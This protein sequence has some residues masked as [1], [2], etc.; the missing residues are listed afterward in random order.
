[1]QVK[2]VHFIVFV[3]LMSALGVGLSFL[4]AALPN[5][6]MILA[7]FLLMLSYAGWTVGST[8]MLVTLL[9]ANLRSGG[10]GPWT[11]FQILAYLII[12]VLWMLTTKLPP[13]RQQRL[14]QTILA[15]ILAFSFGFWNA[16]FNVPFYRI[17]NFGIYYLQGLPFDGAYAVATGLSYYFMDRYLRPILQR[18]VPEFARKE[19]QHGN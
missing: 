1:M 10:V 13:L 16:L 7:F 6:S 17:P 4:T 14:P 18:R 15:A 8:V 5:F 19:H 2:S 3:A 12:F 11:L 9:A